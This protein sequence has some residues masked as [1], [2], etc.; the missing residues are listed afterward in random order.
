M[1]D[2]QDEVR[3]PK[4]VAGIVT[5]GI[6]GQGRD[7]SARGRSPYTQAITAGMVL[8]V[9]CLLPLALS[10]YN[11]SL[12]S[13]A[14]IYAMAAMGQTVLT[15]IANQ[16]SLGNSAFLLIGAYASASFTTDLHLPFAGA[17][18]LAVLLAGVI[19]YVI[20]LPAL[21]ISGLYLA[22]ATIALVF[23]TQEIL[24]ALDTYLGRVGPLV[25]RPPI[26]SSDRGLYYG[27]LMSAVMVTLFLIVL[28]RSRVGHAWLAMKDSET[29]AV[30]SG[31]KPST[32]KTLAFAVSAS[33][34]AVSGL[35]LAQYD[36]GVTQTAFGLPLSLSLLSMA[37]IG[38]LGSLP[39]AYMG[40]FLITLLPN[41]L[42][43]FP[44]TIGS[45]Q[46]HNSNTL[47]SAVL[48]LLTLVLVPGGLWS[49][50]KMGTDLI[51][52]IGGSRI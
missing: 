10:G 17:A 24:G 46:V 6:E 32:L 15:G 33:V 51:R 35:F 52:S 38:G 43:A 39:G 11:T 14:L 13:L 23:A 22:V 48:L 50:A 9:F 30:A 47:V 25:S 3:T 21:R 8:V 41:I 49:I 34:T 36:G 29:A 42:G 44:A 4:G 12:L 28:T 40:A 2:P 7:W 27:A 20:G 16:P 5:D 19:G 31:I 45:F 37:V 18:V 1:S 26:L